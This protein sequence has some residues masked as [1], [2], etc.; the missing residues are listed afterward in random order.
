MDLPDSGL[1]ETLLIFFLSVEVMSIIVKILLSSIIEVS[2][3]L[4]SVQYALIA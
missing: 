3:S 4:P 2:D 1:S